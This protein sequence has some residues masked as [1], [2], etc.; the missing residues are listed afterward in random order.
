MC[1]YWLLY[2]VD[3]RGGTVLNIIVE[4]QWLIIEPN[5]IQWTITHQQHCI[6]TT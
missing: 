3:T 2:R 6:L 5:A 4:K 1:L